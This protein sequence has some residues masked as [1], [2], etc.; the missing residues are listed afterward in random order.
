MRAADD[1]M[2]EELSHQGLL[3]VAV[4]GMLATFINV[5]AGGGGMIVL[6][7]LIALGLPA[8]IANGT[9]RLGVVTQSIAGTAALRGHTEVQR[10]ALV[11]IMIPTVIGGALGAFV[12]TR[13]PNEF[14]KPILLV[15]MVLMAALIAFRKNTL[16]AP[17]GAPLALSE[18]PG[19]WMGLFLCGMYGG[20]IQAGTG[21]LLLGVLIGAMRYDFVAANAIKLLVTL[22]FG[23]VALVIFVLADKVAWRPAIVLAASSI[24]GARVGVKVMLKVPAAGLRWFVFACVVA[25]C[26][27]AW[28]R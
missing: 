19:S 12:A 13:M 6:P 20:F 7:A 27:V 21:F 22:A 11:P 10:A 18:A 5:I 26:I 15:T 24:V 2:V 3:I 9:Y 8:D 17:E 4:A 25:T 28:L 14:L 16:V 1:F 23:L